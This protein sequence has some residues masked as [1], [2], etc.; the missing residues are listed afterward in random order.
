MMLVAMTDLEKLA[1]R[2]DRGY[3]V[4]LVVML[5]LGLLASAF[6]FAALT[7]EGFG[8]C[9]ADAVLGGEGAASEDQQ[10]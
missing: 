2:R 8:G 7:G 1:V 3:L 4:R 6:L 9:A 5:V 10:N